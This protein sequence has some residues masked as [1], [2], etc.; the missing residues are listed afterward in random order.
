MF[1]NVFAVASG[2]VIHIPEACES[3]PGPAAVPYNCLAL[4][5]AV[6][7]SVIEQFCQ[8]LVEKV[9]QFPLAD[10]RIFKSV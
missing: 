1:E 10:I 5:F 6:S 8:G 3:E 9:V 2:S 4:L 7:F